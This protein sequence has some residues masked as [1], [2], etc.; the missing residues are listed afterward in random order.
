MHSVP[1]GGERV[2][3]D[4]EHKSL[5]GSTLCGYRLVSV[6][7]SGGMADVYR[8]VD[9]Q[10]GSEVAI[11]VLPAA[12]ARDPSYVA[13][14][15]DE[16]QRVAALAH[17]HVVPLYRYAEER[18]EFCI[19]MPLIK[20][21]LR[22]RMDLQR[23]VHPV[24]AAR[25]VVQIASALDAAHSQGLVHRDV[26]PENILIDA[27]GRAMLTDFGIARELDVLRDGTSA[28]TPSVN[29]LP[30]GTPEYMSPEQLRGGA[31]DQRMDVY[32]LGAVLYEMVTGRV[33]H[34][35]MTPY[36]IAIKTLTE[37]AIPPSALNPAIWPELEE[38][39]LGALSSDPQY[40]YPTMHSFASALHRAVLARTSQMGSSSIHPS[41]GDRPSPRR[42]LA[43]ANTAA[44]SAL[45]PT[46]GRG[47]ISHH[48]DLEST[49]PPAP[50]PEPAQPAHGASEHRI[51]PRSAPHPFA[52]THPPNTSARSNE[53]DAS[54]SRPDSTSPIVPALRLPQLPR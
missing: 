36:E 31:A 39:I 37:R 49:H 1:L 11:K 3:H 12:L 30:V 18:G 4:A 38:V 29:G 15:R 46:I 43:D 13:R 22:D 51:D 2:S 52:A 47:P 24:D 27:D 5:V 34:L 50:R 9:A 53:T 17:P 26:K 48:F 35:A 21:S 19:I 44:M 41:P 28:R 16:A 33:P 14:F 32:A 23:V 8:A 6:V 40:R 42:H 45:A 25:I 20:E 7:G 10:R 54:A